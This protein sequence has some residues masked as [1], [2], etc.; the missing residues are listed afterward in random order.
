MATNARLL[1]KAMVEAS[2]LTNIIE[3][4][5]ATVQSPID[6]PAVFNVNSID[7]LPLTGNNQGDQAFVGSNNR[8]YIW[9][10][11]GW[12]NIALLNT[13]P[14]ITSGYSSSYN[15]ATDGTPIE[16][17]LVGSDPEGIPITWSYEVTAGSL[18]NGGGTT[19]TV[20]QNGNVFNITPTTNESYAGT[21]SITW[22]ASDGVNLA[23][24]VSSFTLV[25]SKLT[26]VPVQYP[27]TYYLTHVYG[28][29][30]WTATSINDGTDNWYITVS[31]T[32]Q[33]GSMM[34][35]RLLTESETDSFYVEYEATGLYAYLGI[36]RSDLWNTVNHFS[37]S[38]NSVLFGP[39][40]GVW[41]IIVDMANLK[42]HGWKDGVYQSST[43]LASGYNWY[44]GIQDASSAYTATGT[45]KVGK[46][47]WT[48][49]PA[50]LATAQ[51]LTITGL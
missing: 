20:S 8:L 21:F 10:G 27:G 45:W 31:A 28:S 4:V 17:T 16:I 33:L 19:A 12:Y 43:T 34:L 50:A 46:N 24:G 35:N 22:K 2:V 18:T 25:F 3:S 9:A 13:N 44:I 23:T 14:S 37:L 30:G 11:T 49:D 36:A 40:V 7:D 38:A 29:G 5:D 26:S 42:I 32:P 41:S 47:Q 48:Y 6:Y 51:G 39:G 1:A 15:F